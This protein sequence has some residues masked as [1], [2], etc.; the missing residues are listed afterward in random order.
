MNKLG[1]PFIGK[2]LICLLSLFL[3]TFLLL[4]G[5]AQAKIYDDFSGTTVDPAKWNVVVSSGPPGQFWQNN[6][7]FYSGS[8]GNDATSLVSTKTIKQISGSS[9]FVVTIQFRGFSSS[10]S[11][12]VGYLGPS[13]QFRV[14][15]HPASTPEAISIFR[16]VNPLGNEVGANHQ[17]CAIAQNLTTGDFYGF[18]TRNTSATSG[19][20]RLSSVNGVVTVF[21][22][23]TLDP[24]T[25]WQQLATFTPPW[26][27][28]SPIVV[29]SGS[30]SVNG[31]T[32]FKVDNVSI[33]SSSMPPLLLLND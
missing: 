31:T 14:S 18:V 4:T 2:A 25:G 7:L 9:N 5:T 11:Y 33:T 26:G 6:G 28:D 16:G 1:G 19:Q 3:A 8:T 23:E 21:Y 30:D 27:S 22:N 12:P 29:L 24:T 15:I 10:T 32:T 13:S 20:L 17:F